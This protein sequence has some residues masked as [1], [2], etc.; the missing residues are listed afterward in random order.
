[1][2]Q[3][4]GHKGQRSRSRGLRSKVVGQVHEGQGQ[5][6]KGQSHRVKVK[7]NVVWKFLHPIDSREVRHA[8]VFICLI[9]LA[10]H[11]CHRSSIAWSE[12]TVRG[13]DNKEIIVNSL[14]YSRGPQRRHSS[15]QYS[16]V[17]W[18]RSHSHYVYAEQITITKGG[19]GGRRLTYNLGP[20]RRHSYHLCYDELWS[21]WHS[22]YVYA[23]QMVY[24]RRVH[25]CH[26]LHIPPRNG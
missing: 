20:P 26:A 25:W 11:D 18:S 3:G 17:W 15:R 2:V 24:L 21:R 13:C 6:H 23:E 12:Q 8:G 22:H 19:Q 4:Q 14:T 9:A 10:V 7:V 16:D 5:C 1:M